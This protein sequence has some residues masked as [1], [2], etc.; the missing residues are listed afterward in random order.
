[1]TSTSEEQ[2]C[3]RCGQP[4]AS[5]D[6]ELFERMHYVCFHYEFEHGE[7]DVD[8]ECTAGGCPSRPQPV[9]GVASA[10][11]YEPGQ[12]AR[13]SVVFIAE[14]AGRALVRLPSGSKTTV[15]FDALIP[16]A[17]TVHFVRE[18]SGERACCGQCDREVTAESRV[19]AEELYR[20]H[21]LKAHRQ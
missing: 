9:A 17:G 8:E 16:D 5:R 13:I 10:E 21:H 4:V 14:R 11:G 2:Q 18:T 12:F 20:L 3:R 19:S 1:M 15:D 7:F 6:Y